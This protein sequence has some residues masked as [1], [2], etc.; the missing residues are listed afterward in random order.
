MTAASPAPLSQPVN[1]RALARKALRRAATLDHQGQRAPVDIADVSVEGAGLLSPRPIPPGRRGELAFTL[2][3]ATGDRPVTASVRVMHS[4]Y[5]DRA[6]F[7]I[8]VSFTGLDAATA[9]AIRA[10]VEG[11]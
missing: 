10:Y 11:G 7:R 9:D 6:S 1:R 3:L 8:G 5:V 4:T 2:P